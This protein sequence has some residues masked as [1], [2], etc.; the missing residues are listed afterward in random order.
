MMIAMFCFIFGAFTA[1]S[2]ISMGPDT[3]KATKAAM[4]IFTIIRTP[5]KVDTG[6][7]D[8]YQE[9]TFTNSRVD[10]VETTAVEY[11]EKPS[12]ECA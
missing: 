9:K 11:T 7:G 2:S 12:V 10:G 5:S 8:K 6:K 4:K 1:A 3:A